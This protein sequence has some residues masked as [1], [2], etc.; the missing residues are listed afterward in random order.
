VQIKN[1]IIIM[2]NKPT[3]T[4]L[5]AI[6]IFVVL[7]ASIFYFLWPSVPPQ[8]ILAPPN[9]EI[10][11]TKANLPAVVEN[12]NNFKTSKLPNNQRR[13]CNQVTIN[14]DALKRE[15][16]AVKAS[17]I[18]VSHAFLYANDTSSKNGNYCVI[19]TFLDVNFATI[20]TTNVLFLDEN[21]LCPKVCDDVNVA[22]PT[23]PIYKTFAQGQSLIGNYKN[24]SSNAN[25]WM[26]ETK[27]TVVNGNVI[28]NL[29]ASENLILNYAIDISNQKRIVYAFHG[30]PKNPAD[31]NTYYKLDESHLCPK[32]CDDS[33][34]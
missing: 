29:V 30:V 34:K 22:N 25:I 8:P 12:I 24:L 4:N 9:Q 20:P 6:S 16:I 32:C 1:K 2:S 33:S 17:H 23:V 10:Q 13:F 31:V 28:K 5:T 26:D 19:I 21:H 7:L 15:F 3:N 18:R 11:L 14:G 27:A